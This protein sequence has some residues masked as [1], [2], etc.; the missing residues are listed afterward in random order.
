MRIDL[1]E[2]LINIALASFG[3]IVKRLSEMERLSGQK[4]TFAY[5]FVG[6]LISM[7]V[8]IVVYLLCKNYGVSQLLTAGITA[9]SGYMGAPVLDILS[10]IARK[11]LK[12]ENKTVIINPEE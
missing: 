8:G 11:R 6:A 5:Y 12:I 2:I 7:F 3:G 10:N 4:I 1:L 9:L